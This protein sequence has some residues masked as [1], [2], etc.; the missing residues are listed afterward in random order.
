MAKIEKIAKIRKLDNRIILNVKIVF[1]REWFI[2]KW[3]ASRLFMLGAMV[4]GC[5]IKINKEG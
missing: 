4:L 3:I 2:R 1:T 5:D